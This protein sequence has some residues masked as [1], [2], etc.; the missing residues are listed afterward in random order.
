MFGLCQVPSAGAMIVLPG[1]ARPSHAVLTICCRSVAYSIA[2]RTLGLSSSVWVVL[3]G[4]VLMMNVFIEMDGVVVTTKP[5]CLSA[6]TAVGGVYSPMKST[7][8][9]FSAWTIA[10]AFEKNCSPNPS[11]L[12]LGPH[13]YG[14]RLN[15]AYWFAL[16]L[17]SSNGPPETMGFPLA[18]GTFGTVLSLAPLPVKNGAQTCFGST[19]MLCICASTL[20]TAV[21][22]LMIRVVEFG[23]DAP[24]MC[25]SS[26]AHWPA[27]PFLYFMTSLI[28][29]AT[30][31][32]V[33]GFPS[34]HSAFATVWKVQVRPSGE[35]DQLCAKSG[36]ICSLELYC[37]SCG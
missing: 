19:D 32:A 6:A 17:T 33:S 1:W 3:C 35:T 14:F 9:F 2:C 31:A 21:E 22:Y 34:D 13:Q 8:P 23:A 10:S 30:S 20:A 37:T 4:L 25:S 18:G 28:V 26:P 27:G 36:M 16:Y 24:V 12:G 7:W 11:I 29:H 15:S 5:A